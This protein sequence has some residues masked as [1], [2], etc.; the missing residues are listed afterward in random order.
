MEVPHGSMV[1]FH[2]PE[3]PFLGIIY[4]NCALFSVN[5]LTLTE[6]DYADPFINTAALSRV[7]CV[8]CGDEGFNV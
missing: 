3:G 7:I 2:L 4:W 6:S 5:I 1:I 8:R